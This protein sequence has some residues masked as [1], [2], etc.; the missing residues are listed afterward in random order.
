MMATSHINSVYLCYRKRVYRPSKKERKGG[1]KTVDTAQRPMGS[2]VYA[3]PINGLANRTQVWLDNSSYDPTITAGQNTTLEGPPTTPPVKPNN[4]SSTNSK[5]ATPALSVKSGTVTLT[6]Y[7]QKNSNS[8]SPIPDPESESVA[9]RPFSELTQSQSIGGSPKF[10]SRP[11]TAT[12]AGRDGGYTTSTKSLMTPSSS[13][14][15][16]FNYAFQEASSAA[17]DLYKLAVSLESDLSHGHSE[18]NLRTR[19]LSNSEQRKRP[20]SEIDIK[21]H[22]LSDEYDSLEPSPDMK[23]EEGGAYGVVTDSMDLD[24]K[25]LEELAAESAA[26]ASL[27]GTPD[28]YAYKPPTS[29][30]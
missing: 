7:D 13:E 26:L 29:E 22:R 12:P 15:N 8:S 3:L 25:V 5:A 24:F 23:E 14:R 20:L 28:P 4:V 27:S 6:Y 11:G 1:E 2:Q 19:G 9:K 18:L 17:D 21:N 16:S 30:P 10:Y